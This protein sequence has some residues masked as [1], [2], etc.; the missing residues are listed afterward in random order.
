M[1]TYSLAGMA[2]RGACALAIAIPAVSLA[3]DG[4]DA[5]PGISPSVAGKD[6]FPMTQQDCTALPAHM[7]EYRADE[8]RERKA[9]CEKQSGAGGGSNAR[10]YES[11]RKGSP[12]N[13]ADS[14]RD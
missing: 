13:T 6:Y 8:Y 9:Y 14:M 5:I 2:I 11:T 12:D 7:G 1:I 4:V 10:S 3:A